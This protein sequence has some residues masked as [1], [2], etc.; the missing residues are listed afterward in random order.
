MTS[1]SRR[2]RKDDGNS[3]PSAR[4]FRKIN[5]RKIPAVLNK[6]V[7]SVYFQPIISVK[8]GT[9]YGYEAFTWIEEENSPVATSKLFQKAKRI[10]AVS[11]LDYLSLVHVV[12]RAADLGLAQKDIV[13][14]IKVSPDALTNPVYR[15]D[16]IGGF[17]ERWGIEKEKIVFEITAKSVIRNYDCLKQAIACY[18]SSGYL[19]AID[20]FRAS[21]KG[22]KM[23][24]FIEPDIIKI[25][26]MRIYFN[27]ICRVIRV[28]QR[29]GIKV[30]ATG[31]E[32]EEEIGDVLTM[33][34][35]LFQ[36]D[37]LGKPFSHSRGNDL[38]FRTEGLPPLSGFS[39]RG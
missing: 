20:D 26:K 12:R 8:N 5:G 27:F 3:F 14:F 21:Y 39:G 28:C 36:G 6:D 25:D 37:Y 2:N 32:K 35:E 11:S 13:L 22:L 9:T 29:I 16:E 38:P 17:L 34:V 15:I 23:L 24:S 33:D 4:A 10:D 7:I 30:I 19:I 18:K 31:I 1:K